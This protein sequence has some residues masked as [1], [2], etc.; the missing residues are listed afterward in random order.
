MAPIAA[1][2][3]MFD[4]MN[5]ATTDS[6]RYFTVPCRFLLFPLTYA[7]VFIDELADS[8]LVRVTHNWVA[9][10]S[11]K[12]PVEGLRL[13]PYRYWKVTGVFPESFQARGKFFY[14]RSSNLDDGL[15][16]SDNDSVVMLYREDA[17]VDWHYISQSRVG[18]WAIGNIFVDNFQP[19]EYTLAVWDKQ[20]VGTPEENTEPDGIK[21]IQTHLRAY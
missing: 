20:I 6:Y 4:K 5:D 8:S 7:S 2:V 10:D 12:I 18:L 15:I 21:S 1:F 11:L 3:D 16:L 9:P 13:S 17:S 19:G 14:S